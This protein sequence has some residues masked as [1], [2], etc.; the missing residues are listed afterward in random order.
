MANGGGKSESNVLLVSSQE[1]TR[2]SAFQNTLQSLKGE[3]GN[4]RPEMLDRILDRGQ[5]VSA[6]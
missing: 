3:Y 4:V 5:S 1:E 2:D 6:R